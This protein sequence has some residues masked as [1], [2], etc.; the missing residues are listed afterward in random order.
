MVREEHADRWPVW[1]PIGRAGLPD[2]NADVVLFLASELSRFVVGQVIPTDGG[3]TVAG[4]WFRT[5]RG[6]RWTNRPRDP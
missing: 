4:G 6:G 1:V 5:V 2:D 3:T